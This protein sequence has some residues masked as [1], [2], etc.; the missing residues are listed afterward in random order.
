M[1]NIIVRS[2]E[3]LKLRVTE[4]TDVKFVVKPQESVN[5]IVPITVEAEEGIFDFTFDNTFE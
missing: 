2:F 1:T 3:D 5:I 4:F